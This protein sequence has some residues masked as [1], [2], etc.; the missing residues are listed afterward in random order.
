MPLVTN[1]CGEPNFA[2]V[3]LYQRSFN[4]PILLAHLSAGLLVS[5]AFETFA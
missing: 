5:S 2:N 1:S 4:R 3:R